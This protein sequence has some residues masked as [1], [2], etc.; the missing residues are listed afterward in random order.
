VPCDPGPGPATLLLIR[1]RRLMRG[2]CKFLALYAILCGAA[3]WLG[4][5]D[6]LEGPSYRN[7]MESAAAF[8]LGPAKLWGATLLVTGLL[9]LI[10]HRKAKVLGLFGIAAWSLLFAQGFLLSVGVEPYAGVSGIFAHTFIALTA[11]ALIIVRWV[12]RAL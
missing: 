5:D 9:T 4:G 2:A 6:R 10:P 3:T 12:D 1:Y 7:V 8:D 11:M